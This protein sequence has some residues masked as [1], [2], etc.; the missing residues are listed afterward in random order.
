MLCLDSMNMLRNYTQ[1]HDLVLLHRNH[2]VS[3]E[4]VYVIQT[5][6]N[7][8]GLDLKVYKN[9]VSAMKIPYALTHLPNLICKKTHTHLE[10]H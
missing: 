1:R 3:Q 9:I 4:L 2:S 10:R 8:R 5:C 6:A 7:Y